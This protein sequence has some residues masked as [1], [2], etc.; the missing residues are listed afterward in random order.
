M[1]PC[2]RPRNAEEPGRLQGTRGPATDPHLSAFHPQFVPVS[3]P[4]QDTRLYFLCSGTHCKITKITDNSI[5]VQATVF[6]LFPARRAVQLP[7]TRLLALRAA[8]AHIHD[9]QVL[10]RAPTRRVEPPE[11]E[12][13]DRAEDRR[14]SVEKAAKC[15]R[16]SS[17]SVAIILYDPQYAN[18]STITCG[19]TTF[20]LRY[21]LR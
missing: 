12:A 18:R 19:R 11:P 17:R 1:T 14:K 8:L 9:R 5:S 16:T 15:R 21:T 2:P 4:A 3:L 20:S 10:H 13:C 7:C 6:M